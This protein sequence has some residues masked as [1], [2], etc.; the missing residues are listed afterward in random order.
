M[1]RIL[2][3]LFLTVV[4]LLAGGFLYLGL[5]PPHVV[6]QPVHVTVAPATLAPG[7]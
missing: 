5:F 6:P 1:R 3:I 7:G 4:V 2:A